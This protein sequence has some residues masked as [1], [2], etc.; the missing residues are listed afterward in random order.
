MD[1]DLFRTKLNR[2]LFKAI[3]DVFN[4]K[5]FPI[6]ITKTAQCLS[7]RYGFSTADA[8]DAVI[9][10]NCFPVNIERFKQY[11]EQ[12]NDRKA[13]L[14]AVNTAKQ[15]IHEASGVYDTKEFLAAIPNRFKA[16]EL[17][18]KS[19]SYH[20]L[21]EEIDAYLESY[22]NGTTKFYKTGIGALDEHFGGGLQSGFYVIGSRTNIG[23]TEFAADLAI[24]LAENRVNIFYDQLELTNR[25]FYE[26]L[27][28]KL[29]GSYRGA[30]VKGKIGEDKL[31]EAKY[32]LAGLSVNTSSRAYTINELRI[33]CENERNS[34]Q[35]LIIDQFDKIKL[36]PKL[37]FLHACNEIVQGL[38]RIHKDF[39]IPVIL[40]AQLNRDSE[41]QAAKPRRP[42]MSDFK[43]T[44][45]LEQTADVVI[46]LE[47]PNKGQHDDY[48]AVHIDKDRL[49]QMTQSFKLIRTHGRLADAV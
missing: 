22:G 24:G 42:R 48:L 12:L 13:L 47:R 43:N 15:I 10:A 27:I 41:K 38:F 23:K 19:V 20:D 8:F 29:A 3:K 39:D 46:L 35:V 44:G 36:N 26:T 9:D 21:R 6:D 30:L 1:V 14:N 34:M 4:A 5:D 11:L 28:A 33:R 2:S 45:D 25:V 7:T 17:K 31:R 37:E 18:F 32:K 49:M 16:P 40:L